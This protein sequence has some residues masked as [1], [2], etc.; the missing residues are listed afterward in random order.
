[1]IRYSND[2]RSDLRE[3]VDYTIDN[4]GEGQADRYL[5]EM[6]ACFEQ[7]EQLPGMGRACLEIYPG[8]YKVEHGQHIVFYLPEATG[9]FICR[10]LHK[11]MLVEYEDFLVSFS[12]N[13]E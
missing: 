6:V 3:I 8:L 10:V 9:I 12:D 4:W 11:R 1:V 2:S 13:I 5:T 7:I